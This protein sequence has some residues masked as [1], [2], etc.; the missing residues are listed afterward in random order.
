MRD[1]RNKYGYEWCDP[2]SPGEWFPIRA[3]YLVELLER[4]DRDVKADI[5]AMQKGE[6]VTIQTHQIRRS[7]LAT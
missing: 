2:V 3:D 7:D 6:T 1:M 5:I 4:K